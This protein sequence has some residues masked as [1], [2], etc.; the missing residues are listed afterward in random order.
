MNP[1]LELRWP[2]AHTRLLA[3]I[4][5]AL[6][7]EL[8]ADLAVRAEERSTWCA[9]DVLAWRSIRNNWRRAQARTP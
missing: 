9:V 3:Y 5:D 2:D 4:G 7:E 1:F 8:P 6:S